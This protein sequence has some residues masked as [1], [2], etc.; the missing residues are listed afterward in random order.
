MPRCD[1][2]KEELGAVFIVEDGTKVC[3]RCLE[4]GAFDKKP[5][6]ERARLTLV[7]DSGDEE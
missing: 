6:E 5:G 3:A 1:A 7:L 2:C 4:M